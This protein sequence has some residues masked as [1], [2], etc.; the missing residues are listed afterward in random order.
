MEIHGESDGNNRWWK[1]CVPSLEFL[2]FCLPGGSS[3][4]VFEQAV[5]RRNLYR[6]RTIGKYMA[7]RFR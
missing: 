7:T 2:A 5:N 3:G 4:S 6:P 1:N